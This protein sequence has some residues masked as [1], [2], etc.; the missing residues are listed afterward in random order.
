MT[1]KRIKETRV[2]PKVIT[3]Y[4]RGL[5]TYECAREFCLSQ[6]IVARMLD[7]AG[8]ERRSLKA[9]AYNYVGRR[10]A[11]KFVEPSHA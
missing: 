2:D 7:V 10:R 8:V 5:S 9:A 4:Q 11:G 3:A 6:G 1:D